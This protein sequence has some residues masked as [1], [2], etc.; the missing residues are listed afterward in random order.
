MHDVTVP[1]SL[2]KFPLKEKFILEHQ[3]HKSKISKQNVY[4]GNTR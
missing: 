1:P 2:E 4:K 3:I